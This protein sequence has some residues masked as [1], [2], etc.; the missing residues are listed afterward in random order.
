MDA[1]D[2]HGQFDGPEVPMIAD[3]IA[4]A[5]DALASVDNNISATWTMLQ[6]LAGL[7]KSAKLDSLVD[8]V[9]K[10]AKVYARLF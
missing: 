4:K 3:R 6:P 5:G 8:A 7:F 1:E 10:L 2:A 9:D